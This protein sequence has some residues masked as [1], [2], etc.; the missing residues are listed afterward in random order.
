[1][2]QRKQSVFLLL[3][4]VASFICLMLPVGVFHPEGIGVD[5]VMYNLLILDGNG[6]A[7]YISSP[8]FVILLFGSLMSLIT[9]F[10]YRN[11]KL[12]IKM[13]LFNVLLYLIWYAVYFTVAYI[14]TGFFCL[15]FAAIL[16]IVSMILV[17]MARNGVKSDEALVRAAERIR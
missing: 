12:Q 17:I 6:I 15:R 14:S 7:C 10:L 2:I 5:L 16:P 11:R 9:I 3:A 8:L 1:M 4:A 13:C